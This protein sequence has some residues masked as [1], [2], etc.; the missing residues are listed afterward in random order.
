MEYSLAVAG[1]KELVPEVIE[2]A[3]NNRINNR[4]KSWRAV[5]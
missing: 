3:K 4:I 1:M 5:L 2:A